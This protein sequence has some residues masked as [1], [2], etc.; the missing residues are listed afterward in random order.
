MTYINPKNQQM[1]PPEDALGDSDMEVYYE[2]FDEELGEFGGEAAGPAIPSTP[3]EMR[4]FLS[5]LVEQG[6]ISQEEYRRYLGQVNRAAAY[7]EEARLQEFSKIYQELAPALG[8]DGED[9]DPDAPKVTREQI[10]DLM[11]DIQSG[12]VKPV[13]D[14]MT[15]EQAVATLNQAL[16]DEKANNSTR[17]AAEFREVLEAVGGPEAIDPVNIAAS[18]LGAPPTSID[19]D[20]TLRYDGRAEEGSPDLNLRAPGDRSKVVVD[21][22]TTVTL[23][24]KNSTDEVTI[25]EEGNYYVVEMDGDTFKVNKDAKLNIVSDHVS[26]D[27][28]N[29]N[30]NLTFGAS[31]SK[32]RK[33]FSPAKLQEMSE[34]ILSGAQKVDQDTPLKYGQDN[35]RASAILKDMAA[36]MAETDPE[37]RKEL[38]GAVAEKLNLLAT[39]K[40]YTGEYKG[41]QNDV[42]QLVFNMVYDALGEDG[43]KDALKQGLIPKDIASNLALRLTVKADENLS[44]DFVNA[45]NNGPGWTHQMS[46]DFLTTNSAEPAS[47]T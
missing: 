38:W 33:Y 39:N 21:N 37:K 46:A 28:D 47:G 13:D 11:N 40:N 29:E 7:S 27:V 41:Y 32:T 18:Q 44:E 24:P 45:G 15:K 22:A 14:N 8:A 23:T 9:N 31:N 12:Q 35:E 2:E 16:Q 26:G 4:A 10:V 19:K 17:A 25:R 20:G 34:K 1:P 30:G 43:F 6:R 42:A 36:A 5:G 3:T